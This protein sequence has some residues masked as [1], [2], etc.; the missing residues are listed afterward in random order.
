MLARFA[1]E[2]LGEQSTL[3]NKQYTEEESAFIMKARET[4]RIHPSAHEMAK[5]R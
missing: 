2:M 5:L 1:D 3:S 4:L